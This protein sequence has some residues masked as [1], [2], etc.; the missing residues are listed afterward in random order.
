[1]TADVPA[2][3]LM[4]QHHVDEEVIRHEIWRTIKNPDDL[5][6][7]FVMCEGS[8]VKINALIEKRKTTEAYLKKVYN[9]VKSQLS[10]NPTLRD[11]YYA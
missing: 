3:D 11:Y 7:F 10:K 5:E 9:V 2:T 6:V 8:T 4:A 1:M